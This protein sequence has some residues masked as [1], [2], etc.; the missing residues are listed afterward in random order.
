MADPVL[1]AVLDDDRHR[2]VQVY[3]S[4]GGVVTV[5]LEVVDGKVE[6]S[7]PRRRLFPLLSAAKPILAATALKVCRD[8]GLRL[9]HPLAATIPE[10]AGQGRERIRLRDVLTHQTG[11]PSLPTRA[12]LVTASW[13]DAF[14]LAI[15]VPNYEPVEP[16]GEACYQEWRYWYLL[17][18]FITRI[19]DRPVPDVVRS[20]VLAPLSLDK[21]IVLGPEAADAQA[22]GQLVDFESSD[23]T[24]WICPRSDPQHGWRGGVNTFGSLRAV[25]AFLAA[26]PGGPDFRPDGVFQGLPV[27]VAPWRTG[28]PDRYYSHVRDWG[29]GVML[30]SAKWS[31][32]SLVFSQFASEQAYGHVARKAIA[33]FV[34]PVH[35]VTGGVFGSGDLDAVETR[36]FLRSVCT[37]IY[38]GTSGRSRA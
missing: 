24:S 36:Y 8:A 6:E 18:E 16:G 10:L 37:A 38:R 34:D 11:F 25:V 2:S 9:D 30:E 19:T 31:K 4:I 5:D 27:M 12:E 26:L 13:A 7:T 1:T 23:A 14:A 3:A 29:L 32:R 22:L 17:G 33:A 35:R 15:E 21:E 28:I 20:E